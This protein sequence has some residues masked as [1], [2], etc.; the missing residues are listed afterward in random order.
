MSGGRDDR[1]LT[2]RIGR[3]TGRLALRPVRAVAGAGRDAFTEEAERAL[4]GVMAG[5]LPEAVGRSLVEHRVVERLASEML[6]ARA[7]ESAASAPP[8]DLDQVERLVR[9]ALESPALE[10]MLVDAINNRLTTELAEEI[11]HSPAF[12]RALTNVLSSPEVRHAFERQTAGLGTDVAKASRRHAR[13]ADDSVER[14]VRSWLR[15][16][17]PALPRS[18]TRVSVRAGWRW[19]P[20][21][22]SWPSSSLSAER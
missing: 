16:P 12:K 7:A 4:D 15:R 1:G 5:P 8:V 3:A 9:E 20:T 6:E 14:K 13:Q 22:S 2:G 18:R 21:R 10:R 17:R 19:P 11:T